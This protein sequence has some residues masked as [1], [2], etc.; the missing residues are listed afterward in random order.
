M[1]MIELVWVDEICG[2][3][4]PVS[5]FSFGHLSIKTRLVVPDSFLFTHSDL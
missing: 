5:L 2:F 1:K 3:E 4:R